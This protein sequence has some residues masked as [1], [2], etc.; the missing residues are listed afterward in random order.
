[1]SNWNSSIDEAMVKVWEYGGYAFGKNTERATRFLND[2][3]T[4]N[5]QQKILEF[6][7]EKIYLPSRFTNDLGD[8]DAAYL[9]PMF[10]E[11]DKKILPEVKR[12]VDIVGLDPQGLLR[13]LDDKHNVIPKRWSNID[14]FYKAADVVKMT[15]KESNHI[16]P[17]NEYDVLSKCYGI[18]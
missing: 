5:R 17:G 13:A 16:F 6:S 3:R 10:N 11:I 18:G 9:N 8:F 14:D 4:N 2:D 15:T 7:N 12:Y 1:M